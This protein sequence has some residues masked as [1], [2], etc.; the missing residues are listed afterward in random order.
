MGKRHTISDQYLPCRDYGH[1]WLPFDAVFEHRPYRIKRILVC[2]KC[3]TRRTQTLDRG[4]NIVGN[5][6]GYPKGYLNSGAGRLT[7]ADRADIRSRS[8]ALWPKQIREVRPGT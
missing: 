7:A 1:T 4:F 5:S 3:G 8:T 6:Y 2:G